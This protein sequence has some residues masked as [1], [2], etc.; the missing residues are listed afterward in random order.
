YRAEYQRWTEKI[1]HVDPSDLASHQLMADPDQARVRV[2]AHP[3]HPEV[4]VRAAAGPDDPRLGTRTSTGGPGMPSGRPTSPTH[5][6]PQP[7]AEGLPDGAGLPPAGSPR[8]GDQRLVPDPGQ[9]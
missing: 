2:Y 8:P 6:P 3:F 4:P 5:P 9:G 7:G 1:Q